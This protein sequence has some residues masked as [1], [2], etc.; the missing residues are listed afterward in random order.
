MKNLAANSPLPADVP[1]R[2]A[3]R[4]R[5][6][7]QRR[8]PRRRPTARA[9][10]STAAHTA[11]AYSTALE[12]RGRGPSA[13]SSSSTRSSTSSSTASSARC[14]ADR[15]PRDLRRRALGERL[16]HFFRGIGFTILEGCGLT[17]S[18]AASAVNPWDRPK[19]GTVGQPFPGRHT[20]RRRRRGAG[21]GRARVPGLLEQR[22]G[23][24][25]G[26]RADGWFHTGDIGK[27][28]K[29]GY[30]RSPG[31]RRRSSSP[32]RARTSPRPRWRTT[33]AP[34]R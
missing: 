11:I 3:P 34:T 6:G 22:R 32:P 17:E 20:D 9:R 4:L 21:E 10:S 18:C 15:R 16:G 31:A 23:H 30:L 33:S 28:D 27:L 26:D 25:R 29:D 12:H 24:R 1:P 8:E 13:A 14:S 2:R 7:L 19:I 5:E